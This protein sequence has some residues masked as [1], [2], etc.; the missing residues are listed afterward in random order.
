M[1]I[2]VGAAVS[3]ASSLSGYASALSGIVNSLGH[4]KALL[5]QAWNAEEMRYVQLALDR[6]A[7]ELALASSELQSLSGDIVSVANEIRQEELAREAAARAAAE[8]AAR[9]AAAQSSSSPS[10]R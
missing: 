5:A 1:G 8:A 7:N 6:I 2:N 9:A 3:Q 4:N 10:R